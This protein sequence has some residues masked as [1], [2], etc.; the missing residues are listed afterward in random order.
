MLSG[1]FCTIAHQPQS[2]QIFQD[3]RC[4]RKTCPGHLTRAHS[5]YPVF[6]PY[7]FWFPLPTSCFLVSKWPPETRESTS[8]CWLHTF[9]P[10]LIMG[11]SCQPHA[12]WASQS[13]MF[14]ARP[15]TGQDVNRLFQDPWPSSTVLKKHCECELSFLAPPRSSHP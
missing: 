5:E 1:E 13:S 15:L 10:L 2:L 4:L 8:E 6:L 7:K 3:I 14:F 9:G 11:L 12:L